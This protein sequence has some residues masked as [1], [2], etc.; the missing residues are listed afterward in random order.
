MAVDLAGLT[1]GLV[2]ADIQHVCS[3]AAL[4]AAGRG[5]DAVAMRDLSDAVDR[6]ALMT[7]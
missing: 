6:S 3:V 4:I 2:G 5:A 1:P 7:T